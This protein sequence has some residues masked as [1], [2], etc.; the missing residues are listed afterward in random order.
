MKE[1]ENIKI[2]FEPKFFGRVW[3]VY[4]FGKNFTNSPKIESHLIGSIN[5]RKPKI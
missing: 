3:V 4:K 2:D 5:Y 1:R